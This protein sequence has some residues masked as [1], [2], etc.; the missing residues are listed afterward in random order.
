MKKVLVLFILFSA[1]IVSA[2]AQTEWSWDDFDY[3]PTYVNVS[4]IDVNVAVYQPIYTPVFT[5]LSQINYFEGWTPVSGGEYNYYSIDTYNTNYYL[6]TIK[7]PD[8][9]GFDQDMNTNYQYNYQYQY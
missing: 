3:A 6:N 9:F 7:L 2:Q 8:Y 5:D 1:L 4:V